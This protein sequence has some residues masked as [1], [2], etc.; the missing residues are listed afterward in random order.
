MA[1]LFFILVMILLA[2]SSCK[3]NQKDDLEG[4]INFNR[5][6]VDGGYISSVGSSDKEVHIFKGIPYA[7]APVNDLRWKSP[8]PVQPWKG[9]KKCDSFG[10][11]AM[12]PS[13][14]PFY[15]W[16]EEFLIPEEPIDEDC[17]YLNVWTG[18][19]KMNEKR[20]VIVWIHGGGFTSG[21]GSV[22]IYNGEAMARKGVI[23]VNINYRLG[24]FGFFSHP[25][26][27]RES[28]VNAS[29]NYGLM[30]QI[31]ALKWINDNIAEFGG[32]PENITIA[33]QSAGSASVVYLVA[34]PLA[35]GLFQKA[36][37]QSGAG[38]L[39]RTPG[40]E[41]T[42]LLNL[43]QA[44]QAG[45][46]VANDLQAESMTQLRNMPAS[47]LLSK[48]RFFPH[49]IIDGYV[50]P[51]SAIKI[52]KENKENKISLL[53][54][55]NEDDGIVIG[56]FEKADVYKEKILTQWEA[57]GQEILRLYPATNDSIAEISQKDLQR[58][59]VFGAQNYTLANLVSR[60][61]KDTY[62]YRFTHKVPAGQHKDFGAFH[63][64]EVPYALNNLNFVNRPFELIDYRLADTMS[65]YWVNF[66]VSGNPNAD[67]LL[68]WPEYHVNSREI[69][70]F[71]DHP[72]NGI[73]TDTLN[74]NFLAENLMVE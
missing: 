69:M 25:E 64:G 13:P 70:V 32:D 53:T 46:Q 2:V 1:R 21:S 72:K 12:Q 67:E 20:P 38:L 60:Q 19:K 10:A 17:L 35:K 49:P 30:D 15:M 28:S 34:S 52:Y 40:P 71:G 16:S 66:V 62:V 24:I 73:I 50:I 11:S 26:L 14:E 6:Q 18:A 57:S 43:R 42:A 37:A 22:P 7:A 63:T 29:G 48:V 58:D 41:S 47:D 44:E 45:V 23:Y 51:E 31:A 61:G 54:G 68:K 65:S 9:V 8:A 5:I 33:G 4:I 74:L 55:W 36:I 3:R 27:T 59:I 39:S 56:G